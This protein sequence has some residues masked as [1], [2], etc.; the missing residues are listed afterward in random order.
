MRAH[1]PASV[2]WTF[3]VLA[4]R[5]GDRFVARSEPEVELVLRAAD[6]HPD[7]HPGGALLFR[8]G[9]EW[10]L[11]QGTYP[12]AHETLGEAPLFIVPVGRDTEGLDYQAVFG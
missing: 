9:G 5:V 2:E 10:L 12:L 7:D 4:A 1:Y 8:G 6:P 11:P 3:D